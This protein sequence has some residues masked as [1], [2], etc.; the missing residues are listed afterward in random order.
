M[1]TTANRVNR[2]HGSL[3]SFY[4]STSSYTSTDFGW[5]PCLTLIPDEELE[6]SLY[7]AEATGVGPSVAS[8]QY[9]PITDTGYYGEVASAQFYTGTQISTATGVTSGTLH[10][11]TEG[12]LKFYWHGQVLFI[13]KKT[14]R[15]SISWDNINSANAV[16]GVN[17]GST[18]KKTITHSGSSTKYDVKLM[19]GAIKDPSPASGGGRQWNELLYRVCTG[20]EA[21]QA[22]ANWAS[23]TPN[24]DLGI[25]GSNG[26]Y[27]WCQ[28]VYQPNTAYRVSRGYASLSYFSSGTS[29]DTN[30][31]LGWRPC[32]A[33]SV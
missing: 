33:F 4:V 9:D 22:G 26:S 6:G 32:L 29:S 18:G 10:N 31:V 30:A 12:W 27:T 17:L 19:K 8:L 14:Y 16:Y 2:G 21:G 5:R 28:E 23:F 25:N 7:K 13:A 3:C 1:C 24:T 11:D 15:Y 20:T